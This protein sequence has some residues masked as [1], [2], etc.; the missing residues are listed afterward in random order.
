MFG[1]KWYGV[2]VGGLPNSMD[3]LDCQVSVSGFGI[4]LTSIAIVGLAY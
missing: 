2:E 4:L 3:K 1:V